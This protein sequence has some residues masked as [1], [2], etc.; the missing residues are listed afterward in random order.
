MGDHVRGGGAIPGRNQLEPYLEDLFAVDKNKLKTTVTDKILQI[1]LDETFDRERR[2]VV[3]ILF[4][5]I[6]KCS[7]ESLAIR[8]KTMLEKCIF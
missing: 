6:E 7:S 8:Q 4:N 2:Y 3:C 1:G 5:V